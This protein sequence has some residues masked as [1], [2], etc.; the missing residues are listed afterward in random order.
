MEWGTRE[1]D[2]LGLEAY[3]DGSYLRRR[4]Y[5]TCGFAMM[6]IAEMNFETASPGEDWERLVNDLQANPVASMW[7]PAGG[8]YMKGEDK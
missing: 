3:V 4:V 5:E 6:H 7:R 1:T 2:K 8:K